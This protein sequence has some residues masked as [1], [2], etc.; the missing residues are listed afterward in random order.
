MEMGIIKQILILIPFFKFEL[1]FSSEELADSANFGNRTVIIEMDT[2][3][4]GKTYNVIAQFNAEIPPD[5]NFQ[6][7]IYQAKCKKEITLQLL[8]ARLSF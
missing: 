2:I 8:K 1:R 7:N 6:N 5:L 3:E 4:I